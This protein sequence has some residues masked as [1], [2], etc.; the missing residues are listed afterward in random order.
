MWRPFGCKMIHIYLDPTCLLDVYMKMCIWKQH[1]CHFWKRTKVWG[2]GMVRCDPQFFFQRFTIFHV[3]ASK[4]YILLPKYYNWP[5]SVFLKENTVYASILGWICRFAFK[6][7][8]WH[9]PSFYLHASLWASLPTPEIS[10]QFSCQSSKGH[11]KIKT[12]VFPKLQFL[13]N[14]L[15]NVETALTWVPY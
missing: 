7:F 2:K 3:R 8:I 9:Y 10:Y 1:K 5:Q 13:I 4:R 15:S 6:L 11:I 12:K 14:V